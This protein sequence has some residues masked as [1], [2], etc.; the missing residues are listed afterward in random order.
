MVIGTHQNPWE[1][2]NAAVITNNEVAVMRRT[3]GGGAVF[4]DQGNLNFCFITDSLPNRFGDFE[5]FTRPIIQSLNRLDVE[6]R[7]AHHNTIELDGKKISGSAQFSNTKR[8]FSHG[9]LLYNSDLD[10]LTRVLDSRF[11]PIDS[12]SVAS[13]RRE[14]GNIIDFIDA[15]MDLDCFTSALLEGISE[16][17]GTMEKETLSDAMWAEIHLLAETKYRCWEW[18]YGH[19]PPFSVMENGGNGA[20][21]RVRVKK[22]RI[23]HIEGDD[24]M[25]NQA[26]V[27]KLS[28]LWIGKRYQPNGIDHLDS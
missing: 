7:H 1:E 6:A 22:G 21:L 15:P 19:T 23:H 10:L 17:Y 20:P 12:K 26:I 11:E 18:I 27:P 28:R 14:V 4:H 5:F 9:T 16:G 8:M 3:S 13:V 24:K 2:I 25:V